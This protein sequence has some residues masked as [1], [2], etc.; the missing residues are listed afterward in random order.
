MRLL[1]P[2]SIIFRLLKKENLSFPLLYFYSENKTYSSDSIHIEVVGGAS[3]K[4]K[5][6]SGS[7]NSTDDQEVES[8]GKDLFI[9]LSVNRREIFLGEPIVATVKIYSRVNIA[10]IMKSNTPL[11]TAS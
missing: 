9:N 5:V 7:N 10:G 3:Q 1:I 11:L 6:T 2:M 8:S 4:Q